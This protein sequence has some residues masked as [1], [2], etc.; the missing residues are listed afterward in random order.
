MK[1]KDLGLYMKILTW[2]PGFL[3]VTLDFSF[4]SKPQSGVSVEVEIL[5]Y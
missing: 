1:F 4:D 3:T 2:L 5:F